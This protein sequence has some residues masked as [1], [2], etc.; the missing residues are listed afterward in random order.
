MGAQ[1]GVEDHDWRGRRGGH[2]PG[3]PDRD[4]PPALS[5]IETH[6]AGE[7]T[8]VIV[9]GVPEVRGRDMAAK[10]EDLRQRL[11]HLRRALIHEPRGHADMFGA[12]VLPPADE[13][14]DV[15]VV[16]MDGGG[17][18][19]M[20]GHGTIGTVTAVLQTGMVPSREGLNPVVL[21]TPAGLVRTEALV[22]GG[23]V[24]QVSFVNVPAFAYRREV[25]LELQPGRGGAVVCDIAF[26]GSFFAIVSAAQLGV[27]VSV[28]DLPALTEA[29]L[30]L[31]E[32]INE[33]VQVRHPDL[34]HI[35]GVDLVE[36][37]ESS[38]TPDVDWRNVVVFGS[39]Q[40]DRS[41]CGTGT[42][43]RMALLHAQGRLPVGRGLVQE[44]LIGTHLRGEALGTTTV[45]QYP[46][47]IPR[48]T[49]SAYVTGYSQMLLDPRDP[50][51]HGFVLGQE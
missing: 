14:A 22:E 24:T 48:V 6:T 8:R 18:L 27:R 45:G 28:E 7:P 21:D 50:V 34:P 46:A 16:F 49:G 5:T 47:I 1:A 11:D 43:A 4:G 15:G 12:V 39:G 38:T 40:V 19:N 35:T 3:C 42:C 44:S 2:R 23:A 26:G 32:R 33:E 10:R 17:Y 31:R 36:V 13:R 37:Y 30:R 41:P 25:R 29:A 51:R 20:C 9:G